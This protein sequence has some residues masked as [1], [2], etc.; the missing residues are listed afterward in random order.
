MSADAK[1]RLEVGRPRK[2]SLLL[3]AIALL[4]LG[5]RSV[6]RAE[7]YSERIIWWD[8]EKNNAVFVPEKVLNAV[9]IAELPFLKDARERLQLEVD[10]RQRA[11]SEILPRVP[12]LPPQLVPKCAFIE[13]NRPLAPGSSED[14]KTLVEWARSMEIVAL[15]RVMDIVPG[16]DRRWGAVGQAVYLSIERD[17]SG[18]GLD[19]FPSGVMVFLEPSEEI[20]VRGTRLCRVFREDPPLE[21]RRVGDLVLVTGVKEDGDELRMTGTTVHRVEGGTIRYRPYSIIT[22]STDIPLEDFL[23]ATECSQEAQEEER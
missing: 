18:A 15:A 11:G 13:R 3:P 23:T 12:G 4:A 8:K 6:A 21:R 14:A 1:S 10:V 19:R 17:L 2:T 5:C 7:D 9:P 16:W 20:H 22:D